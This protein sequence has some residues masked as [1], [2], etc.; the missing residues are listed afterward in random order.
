MPPAAA[1]KPDRRAMDKPIPAT[2]LSALIDEKREERKNKKKSR[3]SANREKKP[4]SLWRRIK[5]KLLR[6][7]P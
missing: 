4:K 7:G 5:R 3:Q 1:T 6:R 2:A